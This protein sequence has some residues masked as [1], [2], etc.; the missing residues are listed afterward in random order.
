MIKYVEWHEPFGS[1]VV[2]YLCRA[3]VEDVIRYMKEEYQEQ[4]KDHPNYPY[5]SDE[6][7]LTD[8][9]IINWAYIVGHDDE[10]TT[11]D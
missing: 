1:G 10:I 2:G 5:K 8:F 6:D 9:K 4:Y 11:T 7:A 3:T